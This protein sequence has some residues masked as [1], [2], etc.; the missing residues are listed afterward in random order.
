MQ[1][2]LSQQRLAEERAFHDAQAEQRRHTLQVTP[3]RWHVDDAAYLDHASWIRPAFAR[4]GNLHGKD[5]LDYGCGHG[6]AS[7][8]LAR[9]GA[10]VTA[11]DLSPGYVAECR[12]RAHHNGVTVHAIVADAEQLPFADASFDIIWGNAI[13]HHLDLHQAAAELLRV[14][15]PGGVAVFCE[16]WGGNPVLEFVRKYVPY[17]GKSRTVDETPLRNLSAMTSSFP[18]ICTQGHELFGMVS[19]V[20]RECPQWLHAC[21][22]WL[23]RR[24]PYLKNYCRYLVIEVRRG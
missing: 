16:P 14:L 2:L 22:Q 6:M 7:V 3:A 23:L 15:R 4:M 20:W 17:P 19:R 5:V 8:V 12:Q 9:A 1:I 10:R 24:V 18:Q 11:F 21:D 13:L